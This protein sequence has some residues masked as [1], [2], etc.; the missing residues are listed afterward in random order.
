MEQVQLLVVV[1]MCVLLYSPKGA[2][3]GEG[4]GVSDTG[5]LTCIR[6]KRETS[7]SN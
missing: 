6:T 7:I 1:E 4:K 2:G 5:H 3:G